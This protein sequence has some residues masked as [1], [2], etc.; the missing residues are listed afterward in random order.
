[1]KAGS[2]LNHYSQNFEIVLLPH[3]HLG[4]HGLSH[5]FWIL[6]RLE[7]VSKFHS[8]HKCHNPSLGFAT[9]ASACKGAG[10]EGNPRVTS[11]VPW[12]VG[13]CERMNL[14]TP[15]WALILGVGVPM[16][17]RWTPNGFLN[18][19]RAIA[20]VKTHWIEEFF[21]S[22]ESSWNLNV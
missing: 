4:Q 14:H 6:T 20:K 22:L 12:S 18:V 3:T 2:N 9:K 15:K 21:I 17:S 19:Q 5:V 16:D 1:M 10:Q 7:C 8:C 13:E 11:H